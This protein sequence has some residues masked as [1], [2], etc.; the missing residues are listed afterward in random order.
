MRCW[1]QTTY[2]EDGLPA[3]HESM[4]GKAMEWRGPTN[5]P[6]LIQGTKTHHGPKKTTE[7]WTRPGMII[8]QDMV[9]YGIFVFWSWPKNTKLKCENRGFR[10][11]DTLELGRF[12]P[13]GWFVGVDIWNSK[14]LLRH[15]GSNTSPRGCL[16]R[17]LGPGK[18]GISRGPCRSTYRGE[19]TTVSHL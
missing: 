13:A 10:T 17:I 2:L 7:P 1:V 16:G 14:Y 15:V 6:I 12:L 5:N 19:I 9:Y 4:E 11:T 18:P 8:L 3:I